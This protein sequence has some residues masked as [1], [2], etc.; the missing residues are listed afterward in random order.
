MTPEERELLTKS[1]KISEEN[2]R[3]LRSMRRSARF[4]SFLRLVYWALI[5]GSAI[6]TYYFI[7]PYLEAVMKGYTEMQKGVQSVTNITDSLPS[8][9]SW[10]G[11][12]K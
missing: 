1:I 3:M 6:W 11:G 9:P 10:L 2:N 12:K 7:Q 8:L 4:S 5:I